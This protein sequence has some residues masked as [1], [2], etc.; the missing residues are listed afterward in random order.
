MTALYRILLFCF[1]LLP[2]RSAA[3]DMDEAEARALTIMELSREEVELRLAAFDASLLDYRLDDAVYRRIV[4]YLR[5]WPISSGRMLA[6]SARFYPIFE[7]QLRRANLPLEL[8]HLSIVESAL[9]SW[10]ISPVGAGGL[11]Q[12]MPPTARELGLIVNDELDERLDPALGCAA[13]LEYLRIQYERYGDWALALAAYNSGPGNVNRAIRRSGSRDYWK[14]RRFLPRETRHYVPNFIAAVFLM[15]YHHHYGLPATALPLDQQLVERVMVYRRMSLFQ[16]AQVT[17]LRPEVVVEMNPQ[18]VRG[19]LPGLRGGHSLMVPKRVVPALQEYLASFPRELPE[20]AISLPWTHPRAGRGELAPN[21]Y[22]R[23][24]EVTVVPGDTTA[25]QVAERHGI[26][27]D[28]LLV[29]SN[30]GE[31]DSLSAGEVLHYFDV[32]RYRPLDPRTLERL[33][34]APQL[35]VAGPAELD[36]TLRH[37]L[38]SVPAA[39]APAPPAP[40]SLRRWWETITEKARAVWAAD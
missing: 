2:L 40:P 30:R 8:K 37:H 19:Y 26:P 16:V 14:L 35:A 1:A 6:R 18:Y 28:Q 13:G 24:H 34:P 31:L 10:A 32:R 21:R 12:L 25:R 11:W 22:Y 15:H 5:D 27:V 3:M 23:R 4:N 17:G 38:Q 33:P 20:E 29:W 39:T 36:K 7:E 9:R